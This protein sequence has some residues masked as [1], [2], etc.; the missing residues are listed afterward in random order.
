MSADGLTSDVLKQQFVAVIPRAETFDKLTGGQSGPTVIKGAEDS[1]GKLTGTNGIR[2]RPGI[3]SNG[4]RI[5]IPANGNKPHET[6][7]YPPPPP[8]VEPIQK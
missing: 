8:P 6:L 1:S 2:Y 3:G 5:D 4:P 7:H